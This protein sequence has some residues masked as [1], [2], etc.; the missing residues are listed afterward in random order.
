[1]ILLRSDCLVFEMANGDAIPCTAESVTIELLGESLQGVNQ[2]VVQN[3]AAAVL[4]YFKEEQQRQTVSVGEFAAALEKVLQNLGYDVI[5]EA[6][7]SRAGDVR[8]ADL[9]HLVGDLQEFELTFFPRLRDLLRDQ[10]SGSPRLLRFRNLR[11]CVKKLTGA[12]R[13]CGRCEVMS[14]QIVEYLRTCLSV[15]ECAAPCGL[16]VQ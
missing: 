15:E 14:D 3:A 1:M 4:H 11:G 16:I 10:L 8:E 7:E 12:R 2:E 13:W 9:T 5:H 6:G